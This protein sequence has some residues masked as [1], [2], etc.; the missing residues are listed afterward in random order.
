MKYK[1]VI[2]PGH[3]GDDPGASGNG[4]IEKDLVLDI[5]K[6]MYNIFQSLGVPVYITRLDDSTLSPDERTKLILNAF[7]NDPNVI[8]ISNHINAGGGDGAEIIYALRNKDTLSNL[9][10]DEIIATGQNYRKS[11]QR[12]LPSDSSKDYYFIHRNTGVTEPIIVEY[13]F[14]DSSGDDPNL[15]KSKYKDLANAVVRG[16]SKYIDLPYQIGEVYIVKKGDSLWSI[17]RAYNT[18]VDELKKLNNLS[19]NLLSVGQILKIPVKS[20]VENYNIYTVVKGDTLYKIANQFG[21]T[22]NDIITANNLK[23]N[24]LQIGQKLSIPILKQ[25]NIEYYVQA[26]DS[27]WSIARKFNTTVDEIKKLNN[28]T[29]NLLNINQRLLIPKETDNNISEEQ[30]YYEY[31]VISGDTL[32]SIARKYNTTVNELLSY[33]NLSSTALSLGQKIKIPIEFVYTVKKGDTLY[34]I[35][36]N[37]NTTVDNIK[38]KNNLTSNS[39]SIGQLLLI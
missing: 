15:L 37:Y 39:L 28:L 22:V 31:T 8:V 18:T 30:K 21:V 20:E 12:R 11:Y 25:E 16:V 4:I 23:S 26:G 9:I 36:Q 1:I 5:S 14:L 13:G 19:T 3:G 10:A 35:A 2:D 33:N 34:S 7:G 17:A 29:T 24:T 6:E 27:L 38:K 32:Y